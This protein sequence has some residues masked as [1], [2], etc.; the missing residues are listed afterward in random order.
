MENAAEALKMA[1]AILIFLVAFSI[2]LLF[3]SN[4]RATSD[5]I[6][7]YRDRESFFFDSKYYYA[8]QGLKVPPGG[9]NQPTRVV[10]IET[11]LQTI[12]RAYLERYRIL[13]FDRNNQPIVIYR[14]KDAAETEVNE[15]NLQSSNNN[16]GINAV[17]ANNDDNKVEFVK[18]ILYREFN[19]TKK[20]FEDKFFINLPGNGTSDIFFEKIKNKKFYEFFGVYYQNDSADVPDI[21]KTEKKIIIYKEVE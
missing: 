7:N 16:V 14:L 10:G 18:G 3:F 20:A 11:I 12:T 13:F 4:V 21:M 6:I 19:I 2:I 1:G 9:V 8:Y 5:M 17:I 15:I